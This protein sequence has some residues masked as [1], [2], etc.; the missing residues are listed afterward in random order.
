V[1]VDRRIST[2]LIVLFLVGCMP[3]TDNVLVVAQPKARPMRNMTSFSQ[4]MSCM[5]RLFIKHGVNNHD[6]ASTSIPDATGK[7]TLGIKDMLINAVSNMSRNSKA[8]RYLDYAS[9]S[10]GIGDTIQNMTAEMGVANLNL[11]IP[12]IYIR[13]S[14]SQVDNRVTAGNNRV[15]I[16]ASEFEAG[17]SQNR[18]NSMITLDLQLFDMMT[19]TLI[20][21]MSSSNT[22]VVTRNGYGFD[23]GAQIQKAGINFAFDQSETESSGQGVRNL[24]ELAAIELLGKWTKTP[25]WNC[26][27]IDST[28]P[29]AKEEIKAWYDDM[30]DGERIQFIKK[31]LL[32]FGYYKS[33]IDESMN[34]EFNA[35]LTQYQADKGLV[36]NGVVN[37]ETYESLINSGAG[38]T[39]ITNEEPSIENT[40]FSSKRPIDVRLVTRGKGKYKINSE[41]TLKISL[42]KTGYSRCYYKDEVGDITMIYPNQY[43]TKGPIYGNQTLNIPDSSLGKTF[44]LKILKRGRGEHDFMCIASHDNIENNLPNYL[45]I[46]PLKS[47][48]NV[49]N[50]DKIISDLKAKGNLIWYS[51]KKITI[52]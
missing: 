25:Y 23:V 14:I 27:N 3:K 39:A 51:K 52:N 40:L 8:F 12:E 20:P 42:S 5:D 47:I 28:N 10:D 21:G 22:I 46:S 48:P 41:I 35:A 38:Y 13:G 45:R 32:S 36:P 26:L 7:I 16:N 30:D 33:Y 24:V 15:G 49:S 50:L 37:F 29:L 4:A 34:N 44:E 2:S 6:I 1:S 31:G 18:S 43:Q 17:A 11:S 19:R 9:S